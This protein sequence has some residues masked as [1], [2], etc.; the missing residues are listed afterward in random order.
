MYGLT[1]ETVWCE[2]PCWIDH[3][4]VID[5]Y[6]EWSGE[7]GLITDTVN[8]VSQWLIQ[9]DYRWHPMGVDSGEEKM[10]T[11]S[12][13][14]Y[15]FTGMCMVWLGVVLSKNCKPNPKYQCLLEKPDRTTHSYQ[16]KPQLSHV[17]RN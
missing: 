14:R 2:Q 9:V 3:G 8:G 4:G 6:S 16:T 17:N 15:L 11:C 10:V 1:Y 13:L 5:L 12:N 7:D